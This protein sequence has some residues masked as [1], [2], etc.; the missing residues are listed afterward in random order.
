MNKKHF[1][2][3]IVAIA[4]AAAFAPL[5]QSANA[6]EVAEVG[7]MT[8]GMSSV[9]PTDLPITVTKTESQTPSVDAAITTSSIEIAAEGSAVVAQATGASE[10]HRG[11]TTTN[12]RKSRNVLSTIMGALGAFFFDI[13]DTSILNDAPSFLGGI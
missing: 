12:E 10:V 3:L 13:G 2:K 8:S 9:P 5:T 6:D 1:S 11:S 4:V 7:G